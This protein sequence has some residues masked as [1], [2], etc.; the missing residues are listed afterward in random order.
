[1]QKYCHLTNRLIVGNVF[2]NYCKNYQ[3]SIFFYNF[4]K[5]IITMSLS[6]I[7]IHLILPTHFE[8]LTLSVLRSVQ[9]CTS[10]VSHPQIRYI[11]KTA[12][13]HTSAIRSLEFSEP[14]QCSPFTNRLHCLPLSF[15]ITFIHLRSYFIYF[16]LFVY[17]IDLRNREN[18][19]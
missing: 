19:G 15:L 3:R 8:Y 10:V 13:T 17:I 16:R 5:N 12:S 14:S 18:A 2:Q 4:H 11:P 6:S 9:V 7:I 1:M